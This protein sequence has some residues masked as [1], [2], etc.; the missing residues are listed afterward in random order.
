V[1]AIWRQN[2]RCLRTLTSCLRCSSGISWSE[3]TLPG[4]V[5]IALAAIGTVFFFVSPPSR[6]RSLSSLTLS[7]VVMLNEQVLVNK[8]SRRCLR[9]RA[10]R[11]GTVETCAANLPSYV[12]KPRP[13]RYLKHRRSKHPADS[14]NVPA[15][16][17]AS[18][19]G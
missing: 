16:N 3:T 6:H 18:I 19:R 14:G 12:G 9:L 15:S 2:T 1:M 8:A 5:S 13:A 10:Y 4:G 17:Q 11:L 7:R